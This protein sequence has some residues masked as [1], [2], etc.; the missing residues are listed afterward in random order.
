MSTFNKVSK[1]A[2]FQAAVYQE[3]FLMFGSLYITHQSTVTPFWF[4]H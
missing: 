2:T 1:R 3:V 4:W